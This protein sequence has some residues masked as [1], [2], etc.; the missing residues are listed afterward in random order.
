MQS[1]DLAF[2]RTPS[3]ARLHPDGSEV[4]FTVASTDLD[5]DRYVRRIWLWDGSEARALS[6]GPDDSQP[7]WS[8]DGTT[9]AF[10]RGSDGPQSRQVAIL[11]LRGG[12]A[13]VV[14]AFSK[15]VT[16]VEWSP[17]GSH[18]AVV[19]AEWVDELAD[20]DDQERERR[21][22]RISRFAYRYE[23]MGWVHERERHVYLLDSA[24]L[25]SPEGETDVRQLTEGDRDDGEI[26]WHPDGST[27]AFT[28]ARHD[29]AGLDPG[30]QVWSVAV[31]SGTVEPRTAV[32]FW[33]TPSFD[34]EGRLYAVGTPDIWSHPAVQPLQRIEAN[35]SLT[36][37]TDRL[38]RSLTTSSPAGPHWL[39]DGSAVSTLEESGRVDVVRI[40]VE[41][42]ADS[43]IEGARVVTGL[44]PRGD[45]SAFAV[46][47]TTPTNPGELLWWEDGAERRLTDLNGSL[48][49]NLSLAEPTR[50]VIEREGREIEGW[51]Y[52]P[53]GDGSVPVL[54]NIHG[55]PAAQHGYEFFDE[56]QVYVGAGYGVVGI[57]PRGS[58]GYGTDHATAVVGTWH[59]PMSPDL[60][61]LLAAVDAA[62]TAEP[63]LDLNAW[64]SW[65]G[66]TAD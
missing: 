46:I 62:A 21:P 25:M 17:N 26:A 66:G 9:L 19:A 1:A 33:S 38:D 39:E 37:I 63:R 5:D 20:L 53:P 47:A 13:R 10:L 58:T 23:G 32:G 40:T 18:L 24:S 28:S 51:I 45:G 11:P 60:R 36:S 29:G 52:L 65:E 8:P 61:D 34:C 48:A 14:T 6:A 31:D 2:V 22:R 49:V 42:K 54:L 44:A 4:A 50:F 64:A 30:T 27:L 16:E 12:E 35:G 15:G 56:F 41:G 59:E 7:R 57:N 43:I 55:G 3:D